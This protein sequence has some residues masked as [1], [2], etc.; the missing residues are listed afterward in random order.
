M[1]TVWKPIEGYE[2]LYEVSNT[3]KIRSLCGRYG[4]NKILKQCIGSRGY[5]LVTLCDRK[6]QKTVNVHRIVAEAFLP[7]PDNL[8]CV[9]H[10]DEN[11]KNN[12]VENLEWC[13]YYHNNIYG[14][15]LTKSAM[16]RSKPVRC[17]ETGLIY[18]GGCAAQRATGIRQGDISACCRGV[19]KSAGGFH[20]EFV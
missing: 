18:A 19:R 9:N 5:L 6:S 8:P 12:N 14:S 2:S 4:K 15:R 11:R 16:K 10:K 17:I 3:G 20:W 7:N 13:S 1:K